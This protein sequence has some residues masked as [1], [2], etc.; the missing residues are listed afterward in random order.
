M[1]E[2]GV[3]LKQTRIRYHY[4]QIKFATYIGI[5]RSLLSK[6]ECGSRNIPKNQLAD[7]LDRLSWLTKHEPLEAIVDY[8]TIHFKT[9]D[10]KEI[11]QAFV[12]IG[13]EFLAGPLNA[14]HGYDEKY[15]LGRDYLSLL[16]SDKPKL[17]TVLELTGTGCRLVESRF[18][19]KNMDWFSYLTKIKDY[20]GN[21]TR[22]D[23]SLNDYAGFLDIPRLINKVKQQEFKSIFHTVDIHTGLNVTNNESNGDTIYFGSPKSNTRICFYQKNYEQRRKK[24]IA[25]EDSE[26]INRYELRFRHERAE[27]VALELT[28]A[29]DLETTI[30]ELLNYFITFLDRPASSKNAQIDKRWA[31]FIG[32]H[33]KLKLATPFIPMT[34][35]RSLNWLVHGVAP[36]LQ[37]FAQIDQL[38]GTEL[39]PTIITSG[40]TNDQQD[41]ILR[42][43]KQDKKAYKKQIRQ[44]THNLLDN[45]PTN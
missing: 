38:V 2:L 14:R 13:F 6:I 22:I 40:Q 1:E 39:L 26:I 41:T 24:H 7:I 37:M 9:T 34:F 4:T 42:L 25:L 27:Q 30:F 33:G 29:N 23:L 44:I 3:Y 43:I 10:Y 21:I 11:I 35:E 15:Q 18:S 36:T 8:L 45:P 16:V 17:G 20:Q 31:T 19:E 5:S 12:G 32:D 28:Q